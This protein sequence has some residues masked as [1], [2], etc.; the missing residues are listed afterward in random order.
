MSDTSTH[1]NDNDTGNTN[2][3]GV[4]INSLAINEDD[5]NV[6]INSE[7]K[8]DPASSVYA[9]FS[10]GYSFRNLIEY[11][12]LT[13][14]K[15]VFR[16]YGDKIVYEESNEDKTILNHAL[17]KPY[18]LTDYQFSS[19]TGEIIVAVNLVKFRNVTKNIGKKDRAALCKTA[20]D[21]N[22]Y[23]QVFNIN[24]QSSGEQ[25]GLYVVPTEPIGYTIFTYPTYE[26]IEERP[27]CTIYQADFSKM[28]TSMISVKSTYVTAHG[29]DRGI[30]FK[31]MTASGVPGC[32]RD[33]G[34]VRKEQETKFHGKLKNIS[35]SLGGFS[36]VKLKTSDQPTPK[37]KIGEFGEIQHVTIS[38][39]TIKGLAKLNNL[40]P[41]GTIKVY[42]EKGCPLKFIC[43]IGGYGKLTVYIRSDE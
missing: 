26:R 15:G 37:L 41:M 6:E 11:L 14:F 17:I 29:L 42:V 9:E 40:S 24:S 8:V 43:S 38:M 5:A 36:A 30:I 19:R 28:C 27:N 34:K 22:L 31:G 23:V 18:E 32:I 35:S 39:P 2:T 1:T 12:R 33:F 16:F 10:D 3:G 20:N 25:S 7:W 13:N 21:P 4:D